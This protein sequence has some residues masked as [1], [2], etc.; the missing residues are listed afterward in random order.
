MPAAHDAVAL[1][2][3]GHA[4]AQAPQLAGSV[5][6]FASQPLAAM[7]SQSL[8]PLAHAPAG[9]VHAPAVHVGVATL[10]AVQDVP[11]VPQLWVSVANVAHAPAQHAPPVEQAVP[12]APQLALSVW[13]LTHVDPQHVLPMPQGL[14]GPQ[15]GTH[16]PEEHT[17]PGAQSEVTPA[18][19]PVHICVLVLQWV[20]PVAA[21]SV[22]AV[23][24]GAQVSMAVQ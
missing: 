19:Q 10:A 9:M 16:A 1:E 4:C 7:W 18:R 24:P 20:A 5:A 13:V 2:P 3:T 11:Q 14:V 17:V 21:Q 6:V 15:P 12:H 8:Y 23:Q 22:S